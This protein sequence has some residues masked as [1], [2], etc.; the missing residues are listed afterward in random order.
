FWPHSLDSE[1]RQIGG[2]QRSPLYGRL[3]LSGI[4]FP[5]GVLSYALA[6]LPAA[7]DNHFSSSLTLAAGF[8]FAF[9]YRSRS[10]WNCAISASFKVTLHHF[11]LPLSTA[12]EQSSSFFNAIHR[13][14]V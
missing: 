14:H 9:S 13:H 1:G 3:E 11:K 4:I 7:D 5:S 10:F 8:P 12:S 2:L 6:A